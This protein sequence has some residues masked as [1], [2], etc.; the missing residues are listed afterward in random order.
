[1]LEFESKDD[2]VNCHIMVTNSI[3]ESSKSK[4]SP[5]VGRFELFEDSSQI[6]ESVNSE[7]IDSACPSITESQV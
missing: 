7:M 3:V 2:G 4:K 1:M 5:I 6:F